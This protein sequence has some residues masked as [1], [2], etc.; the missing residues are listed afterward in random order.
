MTA[1]YIYVA[2][3]PAKKNYILD[4]GYYGNCFS[5]KGFANKNDGND[6]LVT[7]YRDAGYKLK[8]MRIK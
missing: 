6:Y 3:H 2:Y 1:E 5:I 4:S 7:Y 8:K